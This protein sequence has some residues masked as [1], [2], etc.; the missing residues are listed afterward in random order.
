MCGVAKSCKAKQQVKKKIVI[1]IRQSKHKHCP[2]SSVQVTKLALTTELLFTPVLCRGSRI[3][4]YIY[5]PIE[6][7]VRNSI[8]KPVTPKT[9]IN[10]QKQISE[11]YRFKG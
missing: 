1:A 5:F 11:I 4:K 8:T 7:F 2:D 9:T 10:Q 3:Y 6:V